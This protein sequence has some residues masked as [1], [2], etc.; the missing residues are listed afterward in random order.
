MSWVVYRSSIYHVAYAHERLWAASSDVF[1]LPIDG[2]SL[3]EPSIIAYLGQD[4]SSAKAVPSSLRP[5]CGQNADDVEHYADE[6]ATPVSSL[7]PSFSLC[8]LFT[9]TMLPGVAFLMLVFFWAA[10]AA[11][12]ELSAAFEVLIC[13]EIT[14]TRHG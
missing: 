7:F 4:L 6:D 9:F 11:A 2:H 14:T 3:A 10:G 5:R 1:K 12:C 13:A 8:S